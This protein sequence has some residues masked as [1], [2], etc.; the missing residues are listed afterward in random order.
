MVPALRKATPRIPAA[1]IPGA[2]RSQGRPPGSGTRRDRTGTCT[3][4]DVAGVW[5]IITVSAAA[6]RYQCTVPGC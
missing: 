3:G 4:A 6:A 5:E 1:I 2:R